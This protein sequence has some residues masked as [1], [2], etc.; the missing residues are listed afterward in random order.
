MFFRSASSQSITDKLSEVKTNI[1]YTPTINYVE[2]VEVLPPISFHN[3][4]IT[5]SELVVLSFIP[6]TK[7]MLTSVFLNKSQRQFTETGTCI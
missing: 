2:G 4:S 1:I 3:R 6:Q 5:V 7:C